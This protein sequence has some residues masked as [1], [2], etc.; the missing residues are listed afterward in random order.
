ML[1]AQIGGRPVLLCASTRE[2]E[3]EL[4]LDAFQRSLAASGQPPPA[5]AV[6]A[7]SQP[8]AAAAVAVSPAPAA[9]LPAAMPADTLLLLVP[10]HPQRFDAV[11][12]MAVTR[13]LPVQCRSVLTQPGASVAAGTQILLGDSMGEMFAYFSACDVA[14]IGG[15]LQPLGGQNLIEAAALGKPVLIGEHT[16]NFAL[17]TEQAVQAGAAARIASADDLMRQAAG[18]LRD[19]SARAAMGRNA[20]AF[21]N[22]HRGATARTLALLPALLPQEAHA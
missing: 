22:Q 21:A 12:Q 11:E 7:A 15:S 2:G 18:L 1:R 4:I 14:F 8:P 10:R 6:A 16:F 19:D 3:E 9:A 17:V 13:G 5:A 20:L